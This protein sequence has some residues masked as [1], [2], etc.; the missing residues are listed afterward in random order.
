M[1][2]LFC[3]IVFHIV[4]VASLCA[5]LDNS[6][7]YTENII[8]TSEV[9][10]L[11]LRIENFNFLKNNEYYSPIADGSTLF[12]FHLRPRVSFQAS[13]NFRIEG[14]VF[15]WQDFGNSNFTH[16]APLFTLHYQK[17][18]H[19]IY[20]GNIKAHLNHQYI[21]PLM[22]FERAI[23]SPLENGFQYIFSGDF[24]YIDAWVNWKKALYRGQMDQEEIRGGLSLGFIAHNKGKNIFR[25]P[26]Q[27]MLGHTG[28]QISPVAFPVANFINLASG[29]EYTRKV[30]NRHLEKIVLDFYTVNSWDYSS[31]LQWPF[32][33]GEGIYTNL[34]FESPYLTL[35]LSYWN[36]ENFVSIQGGELYSSLSSSVRNVGYTEETREL[37]IIRFMR[38]FE[39]TEDI[40]FTLRVEPYWDVRNKLFE[41]SLGFYINYT[42]IFRLAKL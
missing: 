16:I 9:R 24:G 13:K 21:E 8:D 37:L 26:F 10:T 29:L 36:A 39:I 31:T 25:I 42:D 15:L 40:T 28:G 1:R 18:N 17:N 38:D 35:M 34:S 22:N 20:F 14:G 19:N 11:D 41:Y 33:A 2:K 3:F 30:E 23:N 6:A 12:G 5:Q 4:L 27:L 32:E 7:F